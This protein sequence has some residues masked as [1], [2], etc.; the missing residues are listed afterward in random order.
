M[1]DPASQPG[2][3]LPPVEHRP[4]LGHVGKPGRVPPRSCGSHLTRPPATRALARPRLSIEDLLSLGLLVPHFP[5]GVLCARCGVASTS[6]T[7]RDRISAGKP[8][9]DESCPV[10]AFTFMFAQPAREWEVSH[11]PAIGGGGC[12][13]ACA[14]QPPHVIAPLTD[15]QAL[16][17]LDQLREKSPASPKEGWKHQFKRGDNIHIDFAPGTPACGVGPL[18]LSSPRSKLKTIH[19]LHAKTCEDA[20]CLVCGVLSCPMGEP[21]HFAHD[22]CP[23]CAIEEEPREEDTGG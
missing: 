22:G 12:D 19:D 1:T 15:E 9:H 5:G 8:W 7:A 3:R 4:I 14:A 13:P 23:A 10:A 6:A 11:M 16:A 20:E 17:R 2:D 21:M 18:D